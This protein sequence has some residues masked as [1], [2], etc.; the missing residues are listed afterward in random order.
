MVVTII[1]LMMTMS[2]VVMRGFADQAREEATSATIQKIQKLMEQRTEAFERAFRGSRRDAAMALMRSKLAD[3][4]GDGNQSDGIFGV[5]DAVVEILAKKALYRF[6]FPQQFS[7][8]TLVAGFGDAVT[9]VPGLPDTVYFNVLA[10]KV[11]ADLGLADTTPLDV[12]AIIA[13]AKNLFSNHAGSLATESSELL[14][15][16]L[17]KSG[18]F[19]ASAV[20]SDRFTDQEIQDQDGDGLP[21]FVDAWGQPLRFY[22]WP[23][24]LIDIDAPSPF[25]PHLP[26]LS[27]PTDTRVI[28][29]IERALANIV[30]KGLPPAPFALPNG[31]VP[32]DALL[33][34]PDD[35]VGRL[36]AELEKFD[37]TNGFGNLS[38]EYNETNYH[39]PDTFHA[40]L[41]ISSGSDQRLGLFEPNNTANLGN[42]AAFP[43]DL[44]GNGTPLQLSDLRLVQELLLDNITSRNKR[45][46]GR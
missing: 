8:R 1:G 28:L 20:D 29:P 45:S 40:P 39:T 16:T 35:P 6:E 36:Y 24:R 41:I 12:P 38:L 21:E 32:R 14:Y 25:E 9:Y 26:I 33:T 13:Q 17:L 46:G 18:N 10:P 30:M 31:V 43:A 27:D 4:N 19:G 15:F 3:L 42:V 23:T 5:S 22:R 44:D 37:G 11:R 7:D 34:D 2:V